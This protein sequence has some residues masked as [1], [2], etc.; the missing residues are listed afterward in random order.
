MGEKDFEHLID[1]LAPAL[2]PK[3]TGFTMSMATIMTVFIAILTCM[4]TV[5]AFLVMG[6]YSNFSEIK[7]SKVIDDWTKSSITELQT[8][9]KDLKVS[10]SKQVQILYEIREDQLRRKAK[11][12]KL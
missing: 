6:Y 5:C 11:E 7:A 9:V 1:L 2:A 3:E 4:G 8:D 12:G 10:N